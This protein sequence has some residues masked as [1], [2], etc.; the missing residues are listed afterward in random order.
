VVV[1]GDDPLVRAAVGRYPVPVTTFGYGEGNHVRGVDWSPGWPGPSVL[2]LSSDGREHVIETELLTKVSSFAL[3]AAWAAART[4]GRTDEQIRAGLAGLTAVPGRLE[5]RRTPSGAWILCDDF[6]S[7]YETIHHALDVLATLPGR[8]IVVLGGIDAAPN[9]QKTAYQAIARR[10]AEVADELV[11]V[12]G[13][14]RNYYS[15]EL[16]REIRKGARLRQVNLVRSSSDAINA[17]RGRVGEGDVVLIK[18]R[19]LERL[20]DVARG[21]ME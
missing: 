18:G 10:L 2:R 7:T 3:L 11:I 8:R 1:N 16:N 17:L 12:Q 21:L 14:W 20:G 5:R 6:K 9:P 4:A 15:A 13:T 19:T